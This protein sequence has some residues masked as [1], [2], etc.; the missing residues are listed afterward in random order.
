V[1]RVER[2][3]RSQRVLKKGVADL[4]ATPPDPFPLDWRELKTKSNC[5]YDDTVLR[6]HIAHALTLGL[7][8]CDQH[9]PHDGVAILVASGPSV[10]GQLDSIRRQQQRGRPLFAI[11]DAHD[12]LISKGTVPNYAVAIDPRKGRWNCFTH[13]H[14]DVKYLV[15]SQ[16]H[17]DMFAHL[18]GH[19]VWLWHLFVSEPK[20]VYDPKT[21]M[22]GG[23]ATTG[24]RVINLLYT[25]GFRR[26][27]LY[28]YDSC[29]KDGLLRVNG[30]K[31]KDGSL[32][33]VKVGTRRFVC[34]P[35]MANQ[36]ETFQ[37]ILATMP[38]IV[39]QSYGDGL[40]SAI[41]DERAKARQRTLR[42]VAA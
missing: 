38:D 16:C 18:T 9:D 5:I 32:L 39:V 25:M 15:A 30:D 6:D 35:A 42:M 22:I 10:E 8:V 23:G 12:W 40:I 24:M 31:P 11:K 37:D 4:G 34:N 19:Q 29:L 21:V 14:P 17:A 26:F 13:K 28:G 2:Q 36:A 20:T 33:T 3:H 27:E 7:P 41:L 1:H